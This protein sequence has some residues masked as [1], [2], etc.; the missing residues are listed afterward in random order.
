[1]KELILDSWW[2]AYRELIKFFRQ[3]TRLLM[4]VAQPL[5]WLGLMGNMMRGMTNSP[6][7][8]KALG[9]NNYLDFMTPGIIL[10]TVLF[11][12]I[13]GGLS[14]I[15]DRRIGYLEKLLASPIKRGAIPLGKSI[16]SMIQGAMQVAIIIV[17]ASLFGVCFHTGIPGMLLIMVIAMLFCLI[18]SG[19]SLVLSSIIKTHETLMAIVNFFTMPLMFTSNA[20]FPMSVMPAWLAAI[21]KVNP[22]SLAVTAIRELTIHGWV[23]GKILPSLGIILI[24]D[25]IFILISQF[26]FQRETVE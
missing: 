4:I 6:M 26:A 23:W 21:A 14:I 25:I 7:A 9:V 12:G 5:I 19:F 22:V 11:G 2:V 1:M 17:I 13:F 8:A 24:L 3:R 16:S 18:L 15:W 10:M 20:L